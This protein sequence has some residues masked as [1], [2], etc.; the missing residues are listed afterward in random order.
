MA[1]LSIRTNDLRALFA[2]S[3]NR[4]A[5]PG[6]AAPLV[7]E[8]NLFIAQVC[9][10]EAAELKGE[11]FNLQQTD[12]QRRAYDNLILLC[13]PHHVE[14]DDAAL[15]PPDRL[16]AMKADHEKAFGQKL[17]QIDESLLHKVSTE[18]SQ[19]W[20]DIAH[21]HREHHVVS[22]LAIEIDV[23]APYTTLADQAAALAADLSG[24]Q[25]YL[26][27]SERLRADPEAS[28]LLTQSVAC[29][30]NDFEV[31]HLRMTNTLTKLSVTL[32]QM[33]IRY[34]EEF[35]KLNPSDLLARQRLDERKTEFAS[36]ATSVG[37][38]D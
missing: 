27:E 3:G 32:V 15:Y 24:I 29:F 22:E 34:L 9:H 8:K 38:V 28:Q 30:P 17:F 36:I 31:L 18:M 19:F 4:C 35:V 10:I 33:E 11:R 2:R 37:Y 20:K 7:S 6:C 14:T 5:F 16:R 12:E 13:Y 25:D 26:I 21:Q 23:S 1:R